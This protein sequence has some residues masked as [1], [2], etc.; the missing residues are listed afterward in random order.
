MEWRDG[1]HARF[2]SSSS[3]SERTLISSACKVWYS[4]LIDSRESTIEKSGPETVF[5]REVDC[6]GRWWIWL[7]DED[8]NGGRRRRE[9]EGLEFH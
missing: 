3:R 6:I 7:R 8:I 1:E 4:C 5:E 2:S 9:E